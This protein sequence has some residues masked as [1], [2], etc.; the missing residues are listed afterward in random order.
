M[1]WVLPTGFQKRFMTWAVFATKKHARKV[2][3]LLEK[4]RSWIKA[5]IVRE[6]GK[7]E[8]SWENNSVMQEEHEESASTVDLMTHLRY[9]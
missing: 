8:Y 1:L 2:L 7:R 9:L 5:V 4:D 6:H 3:R